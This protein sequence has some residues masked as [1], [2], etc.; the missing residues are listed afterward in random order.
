MDGLWNWGGL[1]DEGE[2]LIWM[3]WSAFLLFFMVIKD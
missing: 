3:S 2:F 1:E